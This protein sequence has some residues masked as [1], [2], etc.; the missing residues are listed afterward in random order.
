MEKTNLV[1]PM[2]F[3]EIDSE[4]M[5]YIEGGVP[6]HLIVGAIA[7]GIAAGLG[8]AAAGAVGGEFA[9]NNGWKRNIFTQAAL[10]VALT[11]AFGPAGTIIFVGFDNGWVAASKK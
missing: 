2:G 9:Y 4:E 6:T 3:V 8:L 7:A 5:T 1:V 10:G 11:A